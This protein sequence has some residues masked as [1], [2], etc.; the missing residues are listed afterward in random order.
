MFAQLPSNFHKLEA[1]VRNM[2]SVA[3]VSPPPILAIGQRLRLSFERARGELYKGVSVSELRKLPFAYW[4]PPAASLPLTDSELVRRYW[5][6]E[7][8]QALASG[9]RRGKRWLSP[10]FFTY[11][12][13]FDADDTVFSE[14]A[15]GIRKSLGAGNSAFTAKM[16]ELDRKVAFFQPMLVSQR[17]AE[18]LLSSAMK[19][20]DV[21]ESY[22]LWPGFLDSQL[23]RSVFGAGLDLGPEKLRE[24][25]VVSRILDWVKR[26]NSP[27]VKSKYRVKF[28]DALLKPW[29]R[30][31]P[32]DQ[33]KSALVEFFVRVYGDPR[34]E[35]HRQFQWDKVSPEALTTLMTWL[36]G[37]TLRGFIRVLE[38]TADE[39]WRYR[40]KFWMAFYDAGHIEEAWLAMGFDA[41]NVAR[42]LLVDERGMG[43]GRLE[44]GAAS[45]QS[46]LILKIGNIVFTEWS[47]NGSLR[48][49]LDDDRQT[50]KLYQ[51][52]YHGSDLRDPISL[53]FHDGANM[54]PE[55][56]HMN[57][58]GG[59]WQRK[60]RDFI[61]HHTG[62][63]MNDRE[64]V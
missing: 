30:R 10:L 49:Y 59:T 64:I 38:R 55:L 44:G 37:D 33:L 7:L 4:V 28:A 34:I 23:G 35:G 47:H 16:F 13:F 25:P 58:A 51:S 17:L 29:Y 14:F 18:V 57:S 20:D 50:P 39:I 46:V 52:S 12:E 41:R 43:F 3:V 22:L 15:V 2:D 61:R 11:C 9:P 48:A 26:L 19:I 40:S 63:Y 42:K 60:A 1:L 24:L 32:P 27:I 31:R 8:P 5:E 45:N 21:L 36:A 56:R 53:D 54:H 6:T 62:L